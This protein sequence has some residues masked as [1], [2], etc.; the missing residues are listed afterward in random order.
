MS[1]SAGALG[2]DVRAALDEARRRRDAFVALPPGT[3]AEEV[4]VAF[5]ALR[6]PLDEPRGTVGLYSAVHPD[7]QVRD[8]SEALERELS[9]LETSLELDREVYERLARVRADDL[10]EGDARRLLEHALRDF[11]RAGVDRDE[12]ERGRLRELQRRLVE[13][14]QTFDRNIVQGGRTVRLE[15]G[16]AALAGL[17]EDY[18]AAHPP[19]ADGSVTLS[20]DPPDA[21][22]VLMYAERGDLRRRMLHALQNRAVPQNLSVLPELLALRHELAR[23]L[24][25][26]S[27]ADFV[28]EDQMV[29]APERVRA[30]LDEI[31][32]RARPRAAAEYAE[33]LAE[34]R[35]LEPGASRVEEWERLY[36]LERVKVARL[37]FDSRSVRPYLACRSVREGV[38]ATAER[39]FGLE[40]RREPAGSAWH[41]EVETYTVLEQGAP[42]ARFHLDLHPRAGKY[43]HAALF[44]MRRGLR[45][46]VLPEAALVANFPRPTTDDPGLLLHGQVTTFFHEFGHLLHALLGGRQRFLAFSGI[47]TEGDF[48]EVPSQLFE[49]WAWDPR[50]L[51]SFARHHRTGEPLPPALVEGLRR[52]EEYGKGLY[53]Q[54]QM[55]YARISLEL[56]HE[57]PAGLDIAARIARLREEITL[58]PPLEESHFEASFG[59]LNGYTALYYT[60]MWSLVI[61]KDLYRPFAPDPLDAKVAGAYRSRVLAPGG[62]RDA[63]DLIRDFLGRDYGLEAWEEWLVRG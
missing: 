25:Y 22:P 10:A 7:E 29:R 20:T 33:L 44:P 19:A 12:A 3:P 53:V 38:L 24:G 14:G 17:P 50:V 26:P 5:D 15:D 4:V 30:F 57:D 40:F 36:L 46:G 52:A 43:K 62:S 54:Q 51:S 59:H 48:V 58:F 6:H 28:T 2:H 35:R 41:A 56:Y 49:E 23:R 1:E 21:L 37:G 61:A 18:R 55:L 31:L 13:L 47:E 63:A 11:R 60:Y 42:V 16:P 39:L 34:K 9:E 45:E 8:V 27:W 32:A